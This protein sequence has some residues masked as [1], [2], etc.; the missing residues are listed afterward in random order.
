VRIG[1]GHLSFTDSRAWK[2]IYGHRVHESNMGDMSK[3]EIFTHVIREMPS[4]IINGDREEHQRF[5]RALSHGFSDSSMRRQEPLIVKYVDLLL[6]RLTEQL[7]LLQKSHKSKA[8]LAVSCRCDWIGAWGI[9]FIA[10]GTLILMAKK[11][12]TVSL[13]KIAVFN[14][15]TPTHLSKQS[16]NRKTM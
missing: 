11:V 13:S 15:L 2:D 7:L 1:P 3:S 9:H 5:R 4:S 14:V 8:H 12:G 10:R 16:S 6:K